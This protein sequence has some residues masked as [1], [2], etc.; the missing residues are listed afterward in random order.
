MAGTVT[1]AATKRGPVAVVEL[2]CTGDSS[3]GSVPNTDI[4]ARMSGRLLALETNPGSTAPTSN[5]DITIVDANGHDVLEGVGANRHTSSTEKVSIV[6][7]GT[8]VNPP[9]AADDVLTFKVANQN[10][11][12]ATY[13]VR[14]YVLGSLE[15]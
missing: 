10:V 4:T 5:Y 2:S 3:D 6:F 14:V 13:I 11:N 12:N 1:Q 9:V 15:A 7:S 8:S